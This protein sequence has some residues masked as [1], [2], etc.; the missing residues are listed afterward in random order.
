MAEQTSPSKP[1]SGSA[2]QLNASTLTKFGGTSAAGNQYNVGSYVYPLDT[3][4]RPDLQHYVGFFINIR[5]KS[6]YKQS[7]GNVSEISGTDENRVNRSTLGQ[8]ANVVGGAAA[9]AGGA[10]VGRNVAGT[11]LANSGRTSTTAKTIGVIG[12]AVAGGVLAAGAATQFESDK[13]FR[14]NDA[15]MLA[16]NGVPSF[17]YRA[18][19]DT[20]ELGS[21]GGLLAGGSSAVDADTL[22]MGAEYARALMLQAAEL[23][24]SVASAVGANLNPGQ[25]MSVGTGTTP[26]PFREQMFKSVDNRTFNF[27]YRFLPRSAQEAANVENI[28][29]RFKFHMH[30]EVTAGGLFYV[31][32]SEFNIV[33]YFNGQPNRHIAKISTCVLTDLSVDYGGSNGFHTFADGTPSEI[34][35]RMG[36][37]ELETLTKERINVGY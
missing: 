1:A 28:I 16:I 36:F 18:D 27:E 4:A 2:E 14:I 7:Y 34:T 10:A 30:P 29:K 15:I 3:S 35:L 32:P 20:V 25:I 13:T 8:R 37:K 23:P 9:A 26:N 24:A 6:K 21:T 12:G 17:R 5:G 31:Y 11:V 22:S 19:Y 33:Y